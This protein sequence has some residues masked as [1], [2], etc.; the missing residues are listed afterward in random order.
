[1][2]LDYWMCFA[3]FNRK[4]VQL[5]PVVSTPWGHGVWM[6]IKNAHSRGDPARAL[7][8]T[9]NFL[10]IWGHRS[11]PEY[12]NTGGSRPLHDQSIPTSPRVYQ[13]RPELWMTHYCIMGIQ[14][15]PWSYC[16]MGIQCHPWSHWLN[17][18]TPCLSMVCCVMFIL[19]CYSCW[20]FS[21]WT[22]VG[23]LSYLEKGLC[24]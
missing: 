8:Q 11:W 15:H 6:C 2:R 17:I 14:C 24:H 13:L 21:W 7:Q 22:L 20:S 16:I 12:S 10:S 18:A 4:V 3:I 23:V 5:K 1:V 19:C 9:R